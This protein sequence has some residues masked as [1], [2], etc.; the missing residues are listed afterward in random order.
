MPPYFG[1]EE[2]GRFRYSLQWFPWVSDFTNPQGD[3]QRS[4]ELYNTSPKEVSNSLLCFS[5]MI[6]SLN[7]RLVSP[8]HSAR[9]MS[10]ISAYRF[11]RYFFIY[12]TELMPPKRESKTIPVYDI[13]ISRLEQFNYI[14][15]WRQD[16]R[17]P[18]LLVGRLQYQ[19]S[20]ES[21]QIK[22]ACRNYLE[23][24][25]YMEAS[26]RKATGAKNPNH[27]A[28]LADFLDKAKEKA[29]AGIVYG[30]SSATDSGEIMP[31]CESAFRLNTV[32]KVPLYAITSDA[33]HNFQNH[34]ITCGPELIRDE[35]WP[36]LEAAIARILW[37]R[38]ARMENGAIKIDFYEE[39]KRLLGPDLKELVL[40]VE[41]WETYYGRVIR[42][43]SSAGAERQRGGKRAGR[44][45]GGHLNG[46]RRC[47]HV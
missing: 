3:Y 22:M 15:W 42:P 27:T 16:I 40:A 21:T 37:P 46:K 7:Q 43:C 45:K 26:I 8:R 19:H 28:D 20:I 5:R 23:K 18:E 17:D 14:T 29:N 12:D 6:K 24:L 11:P 41:A 44:G 13:F 39:R 32:G 31:F 4:L 30:S 10:Y 9:L 47:T 2:L 35:D 36:V 38:S 34:L 1:P 33:V 25:T